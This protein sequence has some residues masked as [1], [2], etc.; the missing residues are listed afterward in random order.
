MCLDRFNLMFSLRLPWE[1]LPHIIK[2]YSMASEYSIMEK[3][4]KVVG[5]YLSIF[6]Y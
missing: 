4:L 6:N 5:K 3:L 1:K 2:Y